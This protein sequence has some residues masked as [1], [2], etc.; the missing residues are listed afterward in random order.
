MT[1]ETL[2]KENISLGLA[3]RFK[4]L[5]RYGFGRKHGGLQAGRHG[6]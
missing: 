3:Y 2:I 6:C 4:G 1:T 5:V